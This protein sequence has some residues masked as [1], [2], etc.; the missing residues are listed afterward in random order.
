MPA[1]GYGPASVSVTIIETSAIERCSHSFQRTLGASSRDAP[2]S[3]RLAASAASRSA[4]GKL[5]LV[6]P[7]SVS[8]EVVMRMR[9]DPPASTSRGKRKSVPAK[10]G[11]GWA[12]MRVRRRTPSSPW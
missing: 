8:H 1:Y 4:I 11:A 7:P 3:S 6:A 5:T 9:T 12:W 2:L 10:R